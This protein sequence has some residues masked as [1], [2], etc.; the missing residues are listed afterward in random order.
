M[1][2][3]FQ[4]FEI[5]WIQRRFLLY[6]GKFRHRHVLNLIN[7]MTDTRRKNLLLL[8]R[9]YTTCKLGQETLKEKK[10]YLI[11]VNKIYVNMCVCF[12]L[13]SKDYIFH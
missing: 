7:E 8:S 3:L 5:I 11:K 13:C 4:F 1:Q 6:I 12:Y 10:V 2:C 9:L